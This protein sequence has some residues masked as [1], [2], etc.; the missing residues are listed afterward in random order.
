MFRYDVP[1]TDGLGQWFYRLTSP[2]YPVRKKSLLRNNAIFEAR[3]KD[4][5][6]IALDNEITE[7]RPAALDEIKAITGQLQSVLRNLQSANA[8]S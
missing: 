8:P 3:V 4:D 7:T 5:L 2:L 6:K 1:F